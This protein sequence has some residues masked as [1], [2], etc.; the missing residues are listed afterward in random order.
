MPTEFDTQIA[1]QLTD[2][3]DR[4][5]YK[6]ERIIATPQSAHIA[7]TDGKEVLNFCANNYLGLADHPEIIAAAK[8]ALDE[9]GFGLASVRFICG[10]QTI[11]KELEA[12][13]SKIPRH[14]GHDPLPL[15][16]RRQRRPVRDDPHRRRRRHQ[17]RTQPRQHHRRHPALQSATPPLQAQRPCRSRNE[18]PGRP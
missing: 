13:L 15:L 2:I 5:L 1:A 10:T 8:H 14:G 12:A 7:T 18:T 3:N 6:R 9:W 11:H 4:G 17:R 16:F